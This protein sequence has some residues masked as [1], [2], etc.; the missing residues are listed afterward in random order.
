M[1][2]KTRKTIIQIYRT[3]LVISVVSAVPMI[4]NAIQE[5]VASYGSLYEGTQW[6][7]RENKKC[8]GQGN[9]YLGLVKHC[10]S[11]CAWRCAASV[12]GLRNSYILCF[13]VHFWRY[14]ICA[15]I[16]KSINAQGTN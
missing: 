12:H 13:C 11:L 16:P 4:I 3:L 14:R 9:I 7:F 5:M 10:Q 2:L 15:D 6:W 1:T 8:S